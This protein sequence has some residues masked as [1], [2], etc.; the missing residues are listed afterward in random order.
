VAAA[1]VVGRGPAPRLL[2]PMGL[3]RTKR[4]FFANIATQRTH[5]ILYVRQ[6][7]TDYLQID[8]LLVWSLIWSAVGKAKGAAGDLQ[9]NEVEKEDVNSYVGNST[10]RFMGSRSG[11]VWSSAR[12]P[13]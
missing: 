8:K 2:R 6:Y 10:T 1:I 3:Q 5:I 11:L 9:K 7:V 13:W 12:N 4:L